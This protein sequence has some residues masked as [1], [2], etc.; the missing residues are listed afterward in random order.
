MSPVMVE[1]AV[2]ASMS[3]WRAARAEIELMSQSSLGQIT[4]SSDFFSSPVSLSVEPAR[5]SA[6]GL[7]GGGGEVPGAEAPAVA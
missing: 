2:R 3:M 7:G 4:G 5:V 6:F 1:R